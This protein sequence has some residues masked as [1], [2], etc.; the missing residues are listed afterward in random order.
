MLA[1]W[2]RTIALVANAVALEEEPW[3]APYP[4]G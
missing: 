4:A 2:Y 1:G 3:A